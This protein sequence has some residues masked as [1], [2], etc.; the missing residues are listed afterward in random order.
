MRERCSPSSMP[1]RSGDR[2]SL[3]DGSLCEPTNGV[4][5]TSSAN[6]FTPL[7]QQK[8]LAKLLGYNYD[9]VYKKGCEN[10]AADALSRQ[11]EAP[12]LLGLTAP[13]FPLLGR[14]QSCNQG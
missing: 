9:L 10:G 5:R 13:T 3:A 4:C 6:G 14:V 8:W 2:T 11:T 7:A 1:L 12:T